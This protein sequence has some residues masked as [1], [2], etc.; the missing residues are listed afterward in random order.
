MVGDTTITKNGSQYV[1]F[2]IP[3]TDLGVGTI[4]KVK[5]NKDMWIFTKPVSVDLCLITTVFLILTGIVIWVIEKPTNKEFQGSLSQQ[6]G[7]IFFSTLSL[8]SGKHSIFPQTQVRL[9]LVSRQFHDLSLPSRLVKVNLFTMYILKHETS[10][11][12]YLDI[13]PLILVL[14]C[15]QK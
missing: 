6:I 11:I 13:Q 12:L 2:T 14:L 10:S 15:C 1:E 3:Y 8:S 9:Y 7:T 4:V 5:A